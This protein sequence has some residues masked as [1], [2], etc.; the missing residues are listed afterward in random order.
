M[1]QSQFYYLNSFQYQLFGNKRQ[2]HHLQIQ[3]PDLH[4]SDIAL[5]TNTYATDWSWSCLLQD[6]DNNGL[7]DIFVTNGIVNRPNDLDYINFINEDTV[8]LSVPFLL[9]YVYFFY[10]RL[11]NPNISLKAIPT[12]FS[13]LYGN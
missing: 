6:F 2:V 4:Y 10:N 9:A 8:M 13:K 3:N 12:Y 7:K 5:M 1:G 11:I